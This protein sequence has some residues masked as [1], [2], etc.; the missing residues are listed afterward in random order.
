M[1]SL[2]L[3]GR[4][5]SD[6]G[7]TAQNALAQWMSGEVSRHDV[8][9]ACE[10]RLI[11][12]HADL[13]QNDVLLHV[14]VFTTQRR[15]HQ[16]RQQVQCTLQILREHCRVVHRDFFTGRCVVLGTDFVKHAIDVVGRELVVAL[17]CHM[18]KKMADSGNLTGFVSRSRANEESCRHAV[19]GRVG[20]RDQCQT[21]GQ[22]AL[23]K[24]H[25]QL[26][27]L[28]NRSKSF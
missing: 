6:A 25:I 19:Y 5:R 4:Q 16:R 8:I 21:V 11:F 28:L 23:L 10:R 22:C 17:E 12:V 3:I 1:I 14:K 27:L 20:F 24:L 18:L 15:L 13:F 7:L 26:R 9:V 2:H